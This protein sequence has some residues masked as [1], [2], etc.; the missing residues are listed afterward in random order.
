MKILDFGSVCKHLEIYRCPN[1]SLK[2][3]ITIENKLEI[4]G[5]RMK[6]LPSGLKTNVLNIEDCDS[7]GKTIHNKSLFAEIQRQNVSFV[8][9]LPDYLTGFE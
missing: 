5:S 7:N 1:I 4:G 6:K 8:R 3:K 2:G 9:I